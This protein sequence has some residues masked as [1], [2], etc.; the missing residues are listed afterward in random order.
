MTSSSSYVELFWRVGGVGHVPLQTEPPICMHM[1]MHGMCHRTSRRFSLRW[2]FFEKMLRTGVRIPAQRDVPS[3]MPMHTCEE[4][5][6]ICSAVNEVGG[7]SHAPQVDEPQL[8]PGIPSHYTGHDYFG[9]NY[10]GHNYLGHNYAMIR[11]VVS[12]LLQLIMRCFLN[13]F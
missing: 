9:H 4:A 7:A 11:P 2:S 3:A 1:G 8:L 12:R 6:L 13:F 5:L 10:L